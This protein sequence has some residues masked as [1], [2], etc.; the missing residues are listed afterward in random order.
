MSATCKGEFQ[1][2]AVSNNDSSAP[3]TSEAWST[4]SMDGFI[5]LGAVL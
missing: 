4:K 2:I 5:W 1:C 3:P